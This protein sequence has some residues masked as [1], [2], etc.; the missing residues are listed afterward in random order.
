ME[1][2][3]KEIGS[4]KLNNQAGVVCYLECYW[5]SGKNGEAK[6]IGKTDSILLGQS[7]TLNINETGLSDEG[8]IWVTA[9]ANVSAGRDCNG[10]TWLK[11]KANSKNTAEF[12]ITGVINF[13]TISFDS[14]YEHGDGSFRGY[15]IPVD[16]LSF[17]DHTYVHIDKNDNTKDIYG[18][19]GRSDGGRQ[20]C[21]GTGDV[22]E[23]EMIATPN[24]LAGIVYGVTGVCHQTA[25]RILYPAQI[26][27]MEAGGYAIS[28]AIYGTY[29]LGE[30]ENNM[31]ASCDDV[32]FNGLEEIG[33]KYHGMGH[34]S[35]THI[36]RTVEELALLA[37]IK[38]G[39]ERKL[40]MDALR[41]IVTFADSERVKIVSRR[42]LTEISMKGLINMLANRI[43]E[44]FAEILSDEDYKN[45]I[46]VQ[47]G[48]PL[49][50]V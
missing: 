30:F 47:K 37:K 7:G 4:L 49:A 14:I 45:F 34:D 13:T 41:T 3:D 1:Y 44:R 31:V 12:T 6:R 8:E 32:Y 5:K 29:G 16:G 48:K 27:V 39:T 50:I 17:L 46:G 20:I 23:A 28:S 40:D 19:W 11:Y 18:C 22:A 21:E 42:D 15:A 25:N 35:N 24:G 26:T 9:F 38:L 43:A 36:E 10:S 33:R 2:I